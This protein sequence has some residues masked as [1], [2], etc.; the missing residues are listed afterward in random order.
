[1]KPLPLK[2]MRYKIH[3][4]HCKAC[5]FISSCNTKLSE[6]L[7]TKKIQLD[8]YMALTEQD[9]LDLKEELKKG[10]IQID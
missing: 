4:F 1:M 10:F 2:K 3:I 9:K 5:R 8:K 7:A 6:L